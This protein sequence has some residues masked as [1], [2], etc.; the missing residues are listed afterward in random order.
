V[1]HPFGH[2][3]ALTTAKEEITPEEVRKRME[4]Y[5]AGKGG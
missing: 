2:I 3:W 5:M 1:T 4:A